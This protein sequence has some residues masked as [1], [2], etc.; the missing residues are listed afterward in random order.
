[1]SEEQQ[2]KISTPY[3][4]REGQWR[5]RI[6]REGR[7]EWA[8]VADSPSRAKRLAEATVVRYQAIRPETV[9]ELLA[10]YA[11]HQKTKGNKAS[12][13]EVCGIRLRRFFLD[14]DLPAAKLAPRVCAAYY[15]ELAARTRPDTHRNMLAEARTFTK[16]LLKVGALRADP[17]AGIEPVGR[18]RRGKFQLR[19]DEARRWLSTAEQMAAEHDGPVAA[20]LTLLLGM[21]A[22]EVVGR[23][24]RDLDDG[25]RVLW[26]TASKTEAGKRRL[27]IPERLRPYLERI[28]S[29]KRP[30]DR[31]FSGT[32]VGWVRRWVKKICRASGVP[33]VCA[34][35]M[36]GLF[37][38]LG[39]QSGTAAH[40]VAATLGHESPAIMLASYAQIGSAETALSRRAAQVLDFAPRQS[41]S[42]PVD[43]STRGPQEGQALPA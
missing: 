20:M 18:R 27:E 19:I 33:E 29:G 30:G 40:A 14:H 37:A 13:I 35:S 31:L 7:R 32:W 26:I 25:G 43:W 34:H 23:V 36:R 9:G 5:C 42:A 24:A 39:I 15:Q 6:T 38:T 16:W 10:R 22:G 28:A 21:R 4:H 12:S 41:G 2:I 8:P 17:L 1:M 3:A 11:E